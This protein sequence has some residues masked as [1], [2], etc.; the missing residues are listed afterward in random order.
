MDLARFDSCYL[1]K[2]KKMVERPPELTEVEIIAL[3]PT[4]KRCMQNMVLLFHM[5]K[6]WV[7]EQKLR[8][9]LRVPTT[10]KCWKKRSLP[11][12]CIFR[13]NALDTSHSI[14]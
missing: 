13:N 11:G 8:S 4:A 6:I 3:A 14:Q 7:K 12:S 9:V 1:G 5:G 2:K 10:G